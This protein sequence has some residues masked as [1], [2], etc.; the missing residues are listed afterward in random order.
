ML[1]VAVG[2]SDA[3]VAVVLQDVRRVVAAG[4]VP[5]TAFDAVG[6]RRCPVAYCYARHRIPG[7]LPF[8]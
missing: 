2:V 5:V 1:A 4:L 7:V 8:D 3:A 6:E